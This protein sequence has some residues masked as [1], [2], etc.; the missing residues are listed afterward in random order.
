MKKQSPVFSQNVTAFFS[1]KKR[2][3]NKVNF[4]LFREPVDSSHGRTCQKYISSYNVEFPFTPYPAQVQ[5][6]Y[7]I[8]E[9][10]KE[11][12]NS[13]LES[14]TGTGKSLALLCSTLAW[15][16]R[17]F[18]TQLARVWME[19]NIK[20]RSTE[21]SIKREQSYPPVCNPST[22][23]TEPE[24][25]NLNKKKRIPTSI[26][27]N[28]DDDDFRPPKKPKSSQI[29]E[30]SINKIQSF[31]ATPTSRMASS[32]SSEPII[33][34]DTENS[35]DTLEV[36]M[37]CEK[38]QGSTQT[39]T[40]D[41]P[42]TTPLPSKS[43]SYLT[44]P[45][46]A[47]NNIGAIK[48]AIR[49]TPKI[50]YGTRTHQQ[51][52][53]VVRELSSTAYRYTPMTILG[54]R[55]RLCINPDVLKTADKTEGCKQAV[56]FGTCSFKLRSMGD[57][58]FLKRR[59]LNTSWD[60]E[61]LVSLG[62]REVACPYYATRLLLEDSLIVFCPYNYLIDPIVKREMRF[63]LNN[64]V[65]LLFHLFILFVVLCA[66]QICRTLVSYHNREIFLAIG[67]D[68]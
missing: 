41:T 33:L 54:S 3:P 34:S 26:N 45:K 52:A 62:K 43:K 2:A 59:H 8:L 42:M 18:E 65:C 61:D 60:I 56:K 64:Q 13:L 51:I 68:L 9:G 20:H 1:S 25:S 24:D 21:L 6:M 49:Q 23:K 63:Q 66:W 30:T 40:P 5:L 58:D 67:G 47:W 50:Y 10:L 14:P 19:K 27:E 57:Q 16:L 28:S 29:S 11:G 17:E 38:P 12:K 32:Y 48:T 53:Q 36:K 22:Y 15:Q 44:A 35:M 46:E 55:D 7:K 4:P 39:H 37:K 31:A